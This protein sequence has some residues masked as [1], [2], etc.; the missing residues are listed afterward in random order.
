MPMDALGHALLEALDTGVA[1]FDPGGRLV[2]AN[3][4]A[5][6]RLEASDVGD[7]RRALLAH[8]GRAVPL[9][10]NGTPLGEAVF[11]GGGTIADT[12]RQ[13]ILDTLAATGGRFAQAARRLGISRT[14]LWRR[15]KAYAEA[16]DPG[17]RS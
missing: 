11:L 10:A 3:G 7:P 12:E 16:R 4:V 15:L 5:R 14:T 17:A 13:L 9:S 1:V 6:R 8:G 2:F